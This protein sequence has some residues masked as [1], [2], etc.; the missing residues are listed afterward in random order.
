ML[1]A[2]ADEDQSSG[3]G[4]APAETV[5][6]WVHLVKSMGPDELDSFEQRTF[7]AW[8]RASLGDLRRAI[9]QRRREF[10]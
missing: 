9:Q 3:V 5:R 7:V 4:P 10:K 6:L 1:L 2:M 8:D